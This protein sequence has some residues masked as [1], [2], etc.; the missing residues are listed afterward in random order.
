[1]FSFFSDDRAAGR[2]HRQFRVFLPKIAAPEP[3]REL[4]VHRRGL[5]LSVRGGATKATMTELE[6]IV[7]RAL[8]CH[9]LHCPGL[10]SRLLIKNAYTELA[11]IASR[12][13][14]QTPQCTCQGH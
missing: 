10:Q 8:W 7:L 13:A 9:F 4:G 14:P 3:L 2:L 12:M 6:G 5:G 11:T 1:M